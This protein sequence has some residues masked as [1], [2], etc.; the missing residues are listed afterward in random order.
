[1]V[2]IV[3]SKANIFFQTVTEYHQMN[4]I[5]AIAILDLL[6]FFISFVQ[7]I[8]GIVCFSWKAFYRHHMYYMV[9]Y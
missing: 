8:T 6:L 4:Y 2:F 1:M 3:G 7:D 5:H 9:L